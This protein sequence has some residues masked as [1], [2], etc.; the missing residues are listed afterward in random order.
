MYMGSKAAASLI[1]FAALACLLV[2]EGEQVVYLPDCFTMLRDP[3][4]RPP[5]CRPGPR[6]SRTNL[7]V[8]DC[9]RARIILRASQNWPAVLHCRSAE[10]PGPRRD[11]FTDEAKSRLRAILQRISDRHVYITS[12]SASHRSARYFKRKET[13]ERKIALLGGMTKVRDL[14]RVC[15]AM[16]RSL[17]L[18]SRSCLRGGRPPTSLLSVEPTS[19]SKNRIRYSSQ[20][21]SLYWLF[22]RCLTL[23][24]RVYVSLVRACLTFSS[25]SGASDMLDDRYF[26]LENGRI[27]CTCGSARQGMVAF[28][29]M[30]VD[31]NTFLGAEWYLALE[32]FRN[33]RTLVGFAVEQLLISRIASGGLKNHSIPPA[34]ISAF[35]GRVAALSTDNPSLYYVPLKFNSK[36]IDAL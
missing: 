26:Y 36:A 17:T 19:S 33:N 4:G 24:I 14:F 31:E 21:V 8:R 6:I 23:L 5:V 27:Y 7:R 34:P 22:V 10:C 9:R 1:C 2:R 25:V 12:A 20:H 29:R 28:L 11:V 30:H 13:G 18:P 32:A 16:F 35:S 3:P 15:V